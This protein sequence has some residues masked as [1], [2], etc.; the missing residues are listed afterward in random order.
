MKKMLK[1]IRDRLLKEYKTDKE[2]TYSDG[3]LDMYNEAVKEI[4][5]NKAK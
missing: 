3:V 5:G 4:E 1:D 2:V